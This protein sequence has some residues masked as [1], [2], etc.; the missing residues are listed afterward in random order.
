MVY[1]VCSVYSTRQCVLCT[2]TVCGVRYEHVDYIFTGGAMAYFSTKRSWLENTIHRVHSTMRM[3]MR[4]F[5]CVVFLL[6]NNTTSHIHSKPN[7][8][9]CLESKGEKQQLN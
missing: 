2:L 5:A 7:K 3:R 4:M 1:G 8:N 6:I 9:I